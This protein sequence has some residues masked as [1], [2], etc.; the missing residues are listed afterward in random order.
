[1][2]K[3]LLIAH[4]LA[5]IIAVGPVAVAASMFP[6]VARRALADPAGRAPADARILHRVCR[7]YAV[8]GILV[9]VF[10][11][12]TA[13]GMHVMGD[14]WVIVSIALT[15][16]AAVVLMTLVL[17]RQG[18]LVTGAKTAGGNP[19]RLALYTGIFNLLWA[20]VTVLMII[21]PGSTTGA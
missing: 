19:A 8:A 9:P 6:S 13:G 18:A 16:L 4:V 14:A 11:L 12:A 3:I 20:A 2:T 15:G 17:P 1:M 7:V 10:G 5:A 21:R